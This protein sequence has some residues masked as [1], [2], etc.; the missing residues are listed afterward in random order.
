MC[1]VGRNLPWTSK[2]LLS[3]NQLR[4]VVVGWP[5]CRHAYET[6]KG[7]QCNIWSTRHTWHYGGCERS[8][9][10]SAALVQKL[11]INETSTKEKAVAFPALNKNIWC[12]LFL[13]EH[14]TE[15]EPAWL[16]NRMSFPCSV[17]P[18]RLTK[19]SRGGSQMRFAKGDQKLWIKCSEGWI[20]TSECG[21][22]R[23]VYLYFPLVVKEFATEKDKT[24][25]KDVLKQ[26]NE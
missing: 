16:F 3:H 22:S 5:V 12:A 8:V 11:S 13:T 15:D 23:N 21:G 26:K 17:W 9:Q 1:P 20:I 14:Q 6:N 19:G 4:G 18:C 25:S 7:S 24:V 2:V 10:M